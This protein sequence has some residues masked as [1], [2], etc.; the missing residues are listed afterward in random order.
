MADV[1]H[2]DL[3]TELDDVEV[4][5]VGDWT[6]ANGYQHQWTTDDIDTMI[7]TYMNQTAEHPWVAPVVLG[8]PVDNSPAYGWVE[9]LY[10]VGDVMMARLVK[11]NKAF[12]QMLK[13]GSFKNRSI[14]IDGDN[15]LWHIGFLGAVPPAVDGLAPIEFNSPK[16]AHLFEFSLKGFSLDG[17][18]SGTGVSVPADPVA[19][20][21]GTMTIDQAK[22]AQEARSTLYGIKVLQDKGSM[23]KP[24]AWAHLTDDQFADPVNYRFPLATVELF[25][26]S[27]RV[28]NSWDSEYNED[29]RILIYSRLY[30]AMTLLG[31]NEKDYYFNRKPAG[32][33]QATGIYSLLFAAGIMNPTLQAFVEWLKQ[34]YNEDTG[35]QTA[36]KIAELEAAMAEQL[37]AWITE[38]F[39]EE[40]GAAA[41]TKLGELLSAQ[42]TTETTA[43]GDAT[44]AAAATTP[45]PPTLAPGT[46]PAYSKNEIAMQ[47]RIAQLEKERRTERHEAFCSNL[48]KDG[49][50]L[51]A[52][53]PLIMT[54]LENAFLSDAAGVTIGSHDAN[55]KLYSEMKP[56]L[57]LNE[58]ATP[59]RAAATGKGKSKVP[60]NATPESIEQYNRIDA[61]AKANKM[62]FSQA[63][64]AMAKEGEL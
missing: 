1:T 32:G 8:H 25:K 63:Y 53:K 30:A 26:A 38:T 40:T 17:L 37:G 51:P 61:Y 20:D 46:Q 29:E 62:T 50:I 59:G 42:G 3:P 39:G 47:N 44:T 57:N 7:D 19:V 2:D 55:L 6:S 58:V 4:F 16:R 11:L 5:R 9:K 43:T 27:M 22:A 48:L 10:R 41:I 24:Q 13:D 64:T 18:L 21:T 49:R 31:L 23:V 54:T 45:P 12:V 35:N 56:Q 36:A 33:Q 60:S 28:F 15:M 52:Q 34:T 14:M